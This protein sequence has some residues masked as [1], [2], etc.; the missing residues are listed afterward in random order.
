VTAG[1]ENGIEPCQRL[2][3]GPCLCSRSVKS[4]LAAL[5]EQRF[6]T[7]IH[8]DKYQ[9]EHSYFNVKDIEDE[10]TLKLKDKNTYLF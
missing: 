5:E 1:S 2:L 9:L 10:K 8:S 4:S 6:V 3:P 7:G